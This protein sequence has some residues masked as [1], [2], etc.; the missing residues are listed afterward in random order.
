MLEA[1]IPLDAGFDNHSP[2]RIVIH[3]M[4]EYI[5]TEPVDYHAVDWLRKLGLSAHAFITPSGVVIRG[6][7]D[8]QGAYH[9]KGYNAGSLGVEFL[10][11]TGFGE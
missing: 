6:R 11:D 1:Q 4:G 7:K 8:A 3:A 2:K 5:D 10:T 9:A